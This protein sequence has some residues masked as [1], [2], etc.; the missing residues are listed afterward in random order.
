MQKKLYR[1][2]KDKMLGGVAGGLAEYFDIDPTL[3][4][5]LFAITLFM[6]GTGIIIY[7][8]LWIV[9]PEFPYGIKEPVKPGEPI[10]RNFNPFGD[11]EYSRRQQE[12]KDKRTMF[13]GILLVII[14]MLF[15]ADNFFPRIDFEDFFPLLL[16]GI[17]T[18]LL[19]NVKK[20]KT[21]EG[22]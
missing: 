18:A 19:I 16:I 13:F 17:G 3:V 14:G 2:S 20:D 1:S 5:I 10:E 6:G 22:Q 15:L 7:I 11:P 8:I 4:R 21:A 9:V 12:K